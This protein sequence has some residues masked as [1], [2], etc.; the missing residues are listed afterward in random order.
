MIFSQVRL[1]DRLADLCARYRR[2][3][4]YLKYV[5]GTGWERKHWTQ[6]FSMLKLITKVS[7]C[8]DSLMRHAAYLVG[9][10]AEV[11]V[12]EF[13]PACAWHGIST[14][15]SKHDSLPASCRDQML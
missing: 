12:L 13:L 3:L 14:I 8:A 6:L 15:L 11:V 5:R 1:H 2:C 10:S 9:L 4:P 7:H